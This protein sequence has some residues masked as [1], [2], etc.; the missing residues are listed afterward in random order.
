MCKERKEVIV[1]GKGYVGNTVYIFFITPCDTKS[2]KELV[3]GSGQKF[4][5]QVGSAIFG[6]GLEN[7]P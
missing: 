4:L 5:T 3:V 2:S 1:V 7:F 6:L